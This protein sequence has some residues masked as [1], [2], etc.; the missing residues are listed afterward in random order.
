[1]PEPSAEGGRE[2]PPDASRSPLLR[3]TGITKTFGSL[4]ANSG[5]DLT[6]Y[7]GE[8]HGLLGENGAGKTTLMNILYGLVQPDEGRV[9]VRGQEVSIKSPKDA[10]ALGIG[11]VHQHFMLVPDMTVAE[12]VA[13]ALGGRRLARSHL[14]A[15]AARIRQLSE[16]YGLELDPEDVIEDTSVGVRQ[17][18]EIVKLLYRGA[19]LL[20]MDEPTAALTPPEW[21]HLAEVL[22][23]LVSGDRSV[24]FITH[25]LDELFGV[26][27][28][29]TVLRD[30]RVVGESLMA[31]TTKPELAYQMVGR[32]VSLRIEHQRQVRGKVA[33]RARGLSL[34]ENGRERLSNIDLEV[35]E[36][37]IVGI[38]GVDGNGQRE[39]EEVLTGMRQPTSGEI[40]IGEETFST[41]APQQFK[42]AGGAVV[43]EDRHRTG[44]VLSMS[45]ADNLIL[46]DFAATPFARRGLLDRGAITEHAQ[47]LVS[48][49]DIRC[50]SVNAP[51][52]SLSGGNQQKAV[53]A[54]E[55]YSS[56]RL[57]IAAQPTRG[58]DV[59]AIE[60]VYRQL[61]EYRDAGGA[62][63]LL[64]IELDEILSLADRIAV[65]VQGRFVQTIDVDD[66]D[67]ERLGLL[68]AGEDVP[69]RDA[70]VEAV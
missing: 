29:C 51:M 50:S 32:E 16:E 60:A 54:R 47:R 66:A 18:V 58:L 56:P 11:M 3:A 30:G 33:L 53:L 42:R 4:V 1:M 10:L 21:E 25:K 69:E 17:R 9:E 41:L 67:A 12:N 36:H 24:I 14:G 31:N 70:S 64:S 55:F 40:T 52:A 22:R 8:I 62:I 59:G 13:L 2:N 63:L 65:M 49:H 46:K 20:I 38:A 48:S 34:I 5:I 7:A 26:A 19:D 43:P 68:M 39:L 35:H 15:V 28:R 23:R 6:V 37:E 44:L 45:V 61:I 57:L 27:K